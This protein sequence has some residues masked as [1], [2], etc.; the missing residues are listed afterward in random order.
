ME[1]K[2]RSIYTLSDIYT[3]FSMGICLLVLNFIPEFQI[4]TAC[5]AVLLCV[6]DDIKTSLKAGLMRL[7]VTAIGGSI[8][9]L[10]VLLEN[11]IANQV[12][13]IVF[14]LLG[15]YATLIV[16]KIAKVPVFNARIAG[17]TFIL[18]M[19][20]QTGNNRI[21]YAAFR[22]LSTLFGVFSVT[23]V[24]TATFLCRNIHHK[25]LKSAVTQ[26]EN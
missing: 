24:T 25:R 21:I 11:N 2:N 5:I 12:I 18:V 17:V 23:A 8:A 13:R 20:T 10:I 19:F 14:V 6:Q 16:C 7:I 3:I 4:M 1:N 26:K 22:L 9:I 15:L